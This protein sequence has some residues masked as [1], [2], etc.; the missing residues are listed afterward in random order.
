LVGSVSSAIAIGAILIALNKAET[1]YSNRDLPQPRTPINVAALTEI[2]QAPK[3]NEA[4][5]VWRAAEGNSQDVPP[6]EYLVDNSGR[7]RYLVDPGINGVLPGHSVNFTSP[8]ARLMAFITDGILNR[9]LPWGLVML[10][11][12]IA[13][14]LELCGVPSLPFAVGVYLPLSSST[15]I[16]VGGLVRW[17]ADWR[18]SRAEGTRNVAESDA[19]MSP[20]VLLS[21][22]YIAG[23]AIAGV[24]IAFL[25]FSESIPKVL[26]AWQYRVVTVTQPK[27]AEQVYRDIAKQEIEGGT[28]PLNDSQ[29]REL[30][31]LAGVMNRELAR[32]SSDQKTFQARPD[33][34]QRLAED[35]RRLLQAAA[36]NPGDQARKQQLMRSAKILAVS[37][38]IAELNEDIPRTSVL[39]AGTGVKVPQQNWPALAAFGGLALLLTMVGMGWVLQSQ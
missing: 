25:S 2:G 5:H 34:V 24:L 9:N 38:E 6:G 35:E 19:D 3:D 11:V 39:Q 36:V 17:I 15:P 28:E 18:S 4:Y 26:G 22:G 27:P 32:T 8:K 33:Q 1:I 12:S 14:V 20:G 30:A 37:S 23:G 29:Q 10:G 13:V 31:A 21:T 16:F 7:I